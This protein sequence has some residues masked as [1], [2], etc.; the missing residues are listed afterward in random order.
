M[1]KNFST[2]IGR[3]VPKRRYKL[4]FTMRV[5][6]EHRYSLSYVLYHRYYINMALYGYNV[7]ITQRETAFRTLSVIR[8]SVT[9]SVVRTVCR[10]DIIPR[11][12]YTY[13]VRTKW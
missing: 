6:A 10:T 5:M 8:V 7:S 12:R 13:S 4:L 9:V 11:Y 3:T 1:K 2:R